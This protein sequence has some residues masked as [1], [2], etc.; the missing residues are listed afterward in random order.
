MK[1]I[2][3][4]VSLTAITEFY[5]T[6]FPGYMYMHAY[7]LLLITEKSQNCFTARN[8]FSGRDSQCPD[9]VGVLVPD[10]GPDPHV[11]IA[12]PARGGV[13]KLHHLWIH[14][15]GEHLFLRLQ[16]TS[17]YVNMFDNFIYQ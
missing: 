13:L 4:T 1:K 3:S 14:S 15:R 2:N 6:I 11:P 17:T 5:G 16:H 10:L 9:I 12:L 8:D 7:Q